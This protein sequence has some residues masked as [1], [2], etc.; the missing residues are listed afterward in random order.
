MKI[1][2]ISYLFLVFFYEFIYAQQEKNQVSISLGAASSLAGTVINLSGGESSS[3]SPA[4]NINADLGMNQKFSLGISYCYQNFVTNGTAYIQTTNNIYGYNY[5]AIN[6]K[7]NQDRHNAGVRFLFHF[8]EKKDLDIYAGLRL[9]YQFNQTKNDIDKNL[10]VIQNYN[11]SIEIL[12][13]K[14]N[15]YT[16]QIVLGGK[17]YWNETFGVFSELGIGFPYAFNVGLVMRV[18]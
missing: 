5:S 2:L 10:N 18:N 13:G 6:Y 7:L 14:K 9:S 15:R 3:T 8:S 1:K 12:G 16:Q 17:Y 4:V 11:N